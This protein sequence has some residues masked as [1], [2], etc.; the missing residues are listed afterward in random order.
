MDKKITSDTRLLYV[1]NRLFQEKFI[2]N[3]YFINS[4]THVILDEIHDREVDT[5]FVILLVK[6]SILSGFKGK[7]IN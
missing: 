1:T 5:D 7:V 4:F 6:L 2:Q 3:G